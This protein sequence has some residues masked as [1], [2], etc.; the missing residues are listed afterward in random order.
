MDADKHE[1]KDKLRAEI[2]TRLKIISPERRKSDSEKL[3]AKLKEQSFFQ[4]A[5]AVLFFAPL[6]NEIN[7]WPLLENA[8]AGDKIVAL[9]CYDA[10]GRI[11]K[12]RRVK[13]LHVEIIS[14]QF[15]IREP[16]A[17]C[18]EI[19][20]DDLDLILV[21]GIAFD[22]CGN[23]LGRGKG[24]Y[25][26]LLENFGGTKCGIAFEEQLIKKVPVEPHDAKVHVIVT[27]K[28]CIKIAN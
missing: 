18:L 8:I 22:L 23:R 11:Y 3:C 14:G 9:P 5:K 20:L 7:I 1:L 6:P 13:N 19:P 4:M 12:S 26:K 28:R 10:D 17:G 25:D 24:F 21:P 16:A 15:G 27:P 2:R